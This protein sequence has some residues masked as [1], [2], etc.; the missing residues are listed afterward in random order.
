MA[1]A[2]EST[3]H[4]S[5]SRARRLKPMAEA[6]EST[7]HA[8]L[9]GTGNSAQGF[10]TLGPIAPTKPD[11][12]GVAETSANPPATRQ[13]TR[14]PSRLRHRGQDIPLQFLRQ[15]VT[16][17]F[18]LK[19]LAIRHIPRPQPRIQT[20]RHHRI[21]QGLGARIGLLQKGPHFR[22]PRKHVL[23]MIILRVGKRRRGK[24]PRLHLRF[25]NPLLLRRD[26]T[27]LF[28]ELPLPVPM[29]ED[30]IPILAPAKIASASMPIP[31][32]LE[33]LLIA[34]DLG[35]KIDLNRFSVI[36]HAIVSRLLRGSTG[37]AYSRPQHS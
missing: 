18:L 34:E 26:P 14:H 15:A 6:R 35:I 13:P 5:L 23:L 33:K 1:E 24:D 21:R 3:L 37:I 22:M 25:R 16:L 19:L 17:D 31:K 11:P 30:R 29:I 27:P 9:K 7:L 4:A 8:S 20:R 32:I 28:R 36:A 12:E 2:R 10:L